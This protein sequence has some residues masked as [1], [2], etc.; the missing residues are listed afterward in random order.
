MS[1]IN[2]VSISDANEAQRRFYREQQGS[3][4]YLPN[5]AEVYVQRPEV[6][7]A[8]VKLQSSLRG[9]M[10]SRLYS[11]VSLTAALAIRSSYCALAHAR[12]LIA[13]EFTQGELVAVLTDRPGAPV[14]A[15][16]RCAMALA[17]QVAR[18][19]SSLGAEDIA[20]L[21]LQGF[22]EREVFDVVAAAAARCFFA[23][24]PDALGVLPDDALADLEPDLLKL[25]CVGR[26]PSL[27]PE[28][29]QNPATEKGEGKWLMYSS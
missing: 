15:G 27:M 18:D 22:S 13:R 5:Y 9:P 1:F 16:E 17:R 29:H 7:D 4:D 28:K 24:V 6:M 21:R 11:L 25:L 10:G 3:L 19:S 23:K 14:S 8:W 20:R 26:R 2:V 12:K